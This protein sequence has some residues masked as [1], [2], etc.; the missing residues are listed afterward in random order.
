LASC[1]IRLH[2]PFPE[3]FMFLVWTQYE[4]AGAESGMR[5]TVKLWTEHL[6]VWTGDRIIHIMLP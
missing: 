5:T 4:G 2:C 3:L 1:A 6:L